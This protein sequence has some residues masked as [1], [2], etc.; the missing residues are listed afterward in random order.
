MKKLFL[1]I[2]LLTLVIGFVVY[3]LPPIVQRSNG[4][5]YYKIGTGTSAGTISG[6]STN[7][8]NRC[9]VINTSNA[10]YEIFIPRSTGERDSFLSNIPSNIYLGNGQPI[11]GNPLIDLCVEGTEQFYTCGGSSHTR[12]CVGE[13]ATINCSYSGPC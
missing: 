2:L 13:C 5:S 11:C 8:N 1:P 12:Q 4:K 7:S 9:R 3:A 6:F 10:N